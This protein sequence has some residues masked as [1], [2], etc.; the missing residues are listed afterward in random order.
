[1]DVS[2]ELD[3]GRLV[4]LLKEIV[5]TVEDTVTGL[6]HQTQ[7]QYSG[8]VETLLSRVDQENIS[9]SEW[10]SL[11]A[12]TTDHLRE[13]HESNR[14]IILNWGLVILWSR[15]ESL[16]EDILLLFFQKEDR[17]FQ[18]WSPD[19]TLP[20][21]KVMDLDSVAAVKDR[22]FRKALRKFAQDPVHR[23]V[24]SLLK[25]LAVK[26]EILFT[27]EAADEEAKTQLQG[28]GA[29]SLAQISD[30]RNEIVHGQSTPLRNIDELRNRE[31]VLEQFLL[32]VFMII[33]KKLRMP[34]LIFGTPPRRDR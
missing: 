25:K 6:E 33:A 8:H 13:R 18:S 12:Q 7:Y 14:K 9:D 26:E 23:R 1:M 21:D 22:Y 2:T 31:V 27:L 3:G 32:N 29:H 24:E 17:A 20:F 5:L 4:W 11:V 30:E 34:L 10:Q 19:T 28:W 16:L 15:F